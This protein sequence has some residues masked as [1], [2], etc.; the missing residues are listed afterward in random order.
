MGTK[1]TCSYACTRAKIRTGAVQ[2]SSGRVVGVVSNARKGYSS[3]RSGGAGES[4]SR[5]GTAVVRGVVR[6]TRKRYSSSI[7]GTEQSVSRSGTA[8]VVGMMVREN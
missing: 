1:E 6:N 8:A 5:K 3:S 2:Y 4:A 7:G